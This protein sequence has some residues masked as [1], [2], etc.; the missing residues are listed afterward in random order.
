MKI[1]GKLIEATEFAYDGCHKIYLIT[2]PTGREEILADGYEEFHPIA[3]LP[4][5]W[6]QSCCLRFISPADLEGP[7]IV[8]QGEKAIFTQVDA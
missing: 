5:V 8:A 2:T 1:N 4:Q 6:E 7:N 3:E